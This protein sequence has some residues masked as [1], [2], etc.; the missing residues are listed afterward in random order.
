MHINLMQSIIVTIFI[1]GY[2]I[3]LEWAFGLFV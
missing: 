1:V 2:V 3:F